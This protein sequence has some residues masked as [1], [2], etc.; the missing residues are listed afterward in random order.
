[1]EN[2][3]SRNRLFERYLNDE[4]SVADFREL[5]THFGTENDQGT[6]T[7]LVQAVLAENRGERAEDRER[8]DRVVANIDARMAQRFERPRL[9]RRWFAGAA[10]AAI[11]IAISAAAW[12]LFNGDSRQRQLSNGLASTVILPGGNRATLT[13][14]DGRIID[15]SSEQEGIVIG[16]GITYLDGSK[17]VE[18]EE[19][20]MKNE[21]SVLHSIATPK[22]GTYQVML[23]DGSRVWLNAASTLKYPSRFESDE[24]VV[25]LEGEAFFEIKPQVR[26]GAARGQETHD[27]ASFK[28][29][30]T[31]QEVV[32]LGTQFNISAYASDEETKTTLVE[33]KVRVVGLVE[34]ILT[35]GQQATTRARPD[36]SGQALPGQ[37]A[38]LDI[39][40]VDPHP[41]T[42]WKDGRFHFDGEQI[43]TVMQKLAR[44]YDI[45]VEYRGEV[46]THRFS[47]TMSRFD[48]IDQV[49]SKLS[50]TKQV[51][52]KQEGRKI[53]VMP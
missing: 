35:P 24:R 15:L 42:A 37:G 10:A 14:A 32:V 44:W 36:E 53:I 40:N 39:R 45:E 1:M 38:Q 12:L 9:L 21:R 3:S 34:A 7:G 18:N 26:K 43:H 28:V 49:L 6:L 31:G 4:Y 11:L 17:I 50:K 20:K 13:L 25:L 5:Q 51:Q 27:Y 46:T 30:T 22:G 19:L 47:G 2:P 8:I 29:R 33:G 52:F 41:Y 23:P 48:R 16:D